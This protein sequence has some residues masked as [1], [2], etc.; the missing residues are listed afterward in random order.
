MKIKENEINNRSDYML[1]LANNIRQDDIKVCSKIG[2]NGLELL[3][4][5]YGEDLYGKF[6]KNL[7]LIEFNDLCEKAG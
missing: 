6:I 1:Q 3:K 2:D 5:I 7:S 4:S